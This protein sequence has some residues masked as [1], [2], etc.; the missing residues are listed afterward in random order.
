MNFS[1]GSGTRLGGLNNVYEKGRAKTGTILPGLH[2]T[3]DDAKRFAL[4]RD[5]LSKLPHYFSYGLVICNPTTLL[6]FVGDPNS[7]TM[8]AAVSAYESLKT[9]HTIN[10][11]YDDGSGKYKTKWNPATKRPE[12]IVESLLDD[13]KEYII[14]PKFYALTVFGHTALDEHPPPWL[15]LNVA[16]SILKGSASGSTETKPLRDVFCQVCTTSR[17]PKSFNMKQIDLYYISL[18][19]LRSINPKY[20]SRPLKSNIILRNAPFDQFPVVAC[21]V[22][23]LRSPWEKNQVG[24]VVVLPC[25][26][27]KT[28]I[29][30]CIWHEFYN[31][32]FST[33]D[34]VDFGLILH[35]YNDEQD[36]S[37]AAIEDNPM[38]FA[39]GGQPSIKEPKITSAIAK[40][41][42]DYESWLVAHPDAHDFTKNDPISSPKLL[43]IVHKIDLVDQAAESFLHSFPGIRIGILQGNKRPD[44]A[45]YDVVIASTDTIASPKQV[46]PDGYFEHFG[47]LFCDEAHQDLAPFFRKVFVKLACI[48]KVLMFTATPRKYALRW[49]GGPIIVSATRPFVPQQHIAIMRS[50]VLIKNRPVRKIMMYKLKGGKSTF[51]QLPPDAT[52]MLQ[53]VV[54]DMERNSLI[55]K[56]IMQMCVYSQ[57]LRFD[58]GSVPTVTGYKMSKYPSTS[59]TSSWNAILDQIYTTEKE[60]RSLAVSK[61]S[62]FALA[63]IS[64]T[65]VPLKAAYNPTKSR[66]VPIIFG[67]HVQMLIMMQ[68]MFAQ[69]WLDDAKSQH[70]FKNH[71]L[72]IVRIGLRQL[73]V[74]DFTSLDESQKLKMKFIGKSG[75]AQW[76]GSDEA[77]QVDNL[78]ESF[79]KLWYSQFPSCERH[80]NEAKKPY[81]FKSDSAAGKN[82]RKKTAEADEE[83]DGE[84]TEDPK[85]KRKKKSKSVN[86][87]DDDD[88]EDELDGKVPIASKVL[89]SDWIYHAQHY[90]TEVYH[91]LPSAV[92]E[93]TL[94]DEDDEP[95]KRKKPSKKR[96]RDDYDEDED[97]TSSCLFRKMVLQDKR[98]ALSKDQLLATF[99]LIIGLGGRACPTQLLSNQKLTLKGAHNKAALNSDFV[100]A[101]FSIA[102]TGVDRPE[103]DTTITIQALGDDE[104]LRGRALRIL[105]TK[106]DALHIEFAEPMSIYRKQLLN[107]IQSSQ[108]QGIKSDVYISALLNQCTI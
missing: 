5:L 47:L 32:I 72:R 88:D 1:I 81:P 46:F 28:E 35:K 48:P 23:Q 22:R 63:G 17:P 58:P 45:R 20:V 66:R 108:V 50:N 83:D 73:G 94:V 97:D 56:S 31:P 38:N 70:A 87:D 14:L 93:D 89:A 43:W 101:N 85:P 64:L 80:A 3:E 34:G 82:K 24:G 103:V 6:R 21:G 68:H 19:H 30:K 100:F 49:L 53:D 98:P 62:S 84:S 67:A 39:F 9:T 107:H 90:W 65:E 52:G 91:P 7:P 16:A 104:Q 71:D 59:A 10:L 75:R 54:I 69:Q 55:V 96:K 78:S 4:D 2:H 12:P 86:T 8:K 60:F 41:N 13:L 102:S 18:D 15:N 95:V 25:G 61:T 77:K 37:S 26:S 11:T 106:Q 33:L 29:G 51:D 79:W 105:N 76:S 57:D 44:P 92:Y 36:D 27:G 40:H 99:G 74:V 42:N